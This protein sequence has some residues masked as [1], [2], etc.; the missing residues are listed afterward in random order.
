MGKHK[1][2]TLEERVKIRTYL[3]CSYNPSQ[4]AKKLNRARSTI[5]RELNKWGIK[6]NYQDYDPELVHAYTRDGM[7]AVHRNK[8]KSTKQA[9]QTL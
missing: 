6:E 8:C 2:I 4:I 5:T 3:E 9:N 7:G 1:K